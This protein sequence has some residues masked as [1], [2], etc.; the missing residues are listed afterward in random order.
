MGDGT[1]LPSRDRLDDARPA[2][3]VG[4]LLVVHRAQ[5]YSRLLGPLALTR[6]SAPRRLILRHCQSS[7]P[8]APNALVLQK[9]REVAKSRIEPTGVRWCATMR[10]FGGRQWVSASEHIRTPSEID[11]PPGGVLHW[12]V[13]QGYG[14]KN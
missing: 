1:T 6:D 4:R 9:F 13:G 2:P 3:F 14:V 5:R 12:R 11:D 10:G 8:V 7:S